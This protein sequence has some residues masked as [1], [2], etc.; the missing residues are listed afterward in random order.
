M[1]K[2]YKKRANVIFLFLFLGVI[3]FINFFHTEK[4]IQNNKDCPA[5]HF[6][7]ST[8]TTSQINFFHLPQLYLLETIKTFDSFNYEELF[9]I[10]P[11]SRSPP[12]I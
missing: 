11:A 12:I 6:Q 3:L 4:D 9:Y 5:C 2:K 7:N 10:E 1:T 8:L